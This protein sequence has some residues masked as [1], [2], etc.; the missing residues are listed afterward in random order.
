MLTLRSDRRTR[1]TDRFDE[2]WD[3]YDKNLGRKKPRQNR[4]ALK[5]PGVTA[6]LLIA[7]AAA[8]IEWQ[9]A[10]GKHPQFTKDPATWLN[11]E[12]WTDERSGRTQ[13]MTNTQRHLALGRELAEQTTPEIG[14]R[15]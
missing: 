7:A 4:L 15:R 3:T 13:P 6:D 14:Q 10:E 12:H 11:G 5:K 8:Y 2:F 9:R 1:T